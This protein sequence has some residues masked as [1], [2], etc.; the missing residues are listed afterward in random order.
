LPSLFLQDV[1][2]FSQTSFKQYPLEARAG[3]LQKYAYKLVASWGPAIAR[4]IAKGMAHGLIHAINPLHTVLGP[5]YKLK[6]IADCV[7]FA[8]EELQPVVEYLSLVGSDP[9]KAREALSKC[10]DPFK[11][12]AVQWN[13]MS[14]EQKIETVRL[15][16]HLN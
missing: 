1:Y 9:E 16:R 15:Y 11:N 8:F 5:Y 6:L 13:E 7:A 4:G 10:A 3:K 12:L 2:D 14:D